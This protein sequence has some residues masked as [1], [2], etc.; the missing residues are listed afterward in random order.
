MFFGVATEML[1][2]LQPSQIPATFCNGYGFGY[3][4]ASIIVNL[5]T[6][7]RK[8][9]VSQTFCRW[10]NYREPSVPAQARR[11]EMCHATTVYCVHV[12]AAYAKP[13]SKKVRAENY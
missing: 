13:S 11:E 10:S 9:G 4:L 12:W 7:T 6:L 2:Q 5:F 8:T 1:L 3:F